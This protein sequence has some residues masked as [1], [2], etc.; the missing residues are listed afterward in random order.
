MMGISHCVPRADRGCNSWALVA[1]CWR[2]Y[3]WNQERHQGGGS[4][5][6]FRR[7]AS[8]LSRP[9]DRLHHRLRGRWRRH[10]Y[11]P[12]VL[13]WKKNSPKSIAISARSVARAST[14]SARPSCTL[15]RPATAGSWVNSHQPKQKLLA[16]ASPPAA[17]RQ[18][19]AP[20]QRL[21]RWLCKR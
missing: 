20:R 11:F 8:A 1:R 17:H 18:T 15:N 16:T 19:Q 12:G 9:I 6:H 13:K 7:A 21:S 4:N 10:S 5:E 3:A 2:R 14:P